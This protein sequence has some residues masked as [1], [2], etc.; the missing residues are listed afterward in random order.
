M[1]IYTHP[2]E[3]YALFV[4]ARLQEQENAARAAN[5]R[6]PAPWGITPLPSG[7]GAVYVTAD[8]PH[9]TCPRGAPSRVYGEEVCDH[10]NVAVYGDSASAAYVIAAGDP[11]AMLARVQAQRR[12]VH[13][14]Q[15]RLRAYRNSPTRVARGF[16]GVLPPLRGRVRERF[17][18]DLDALDYAVRRLADQFIPHP[19]H[20][21]LVARLTALASL[22]APTGEPVAR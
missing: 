11:A 8:A 4:L 5:D 10:L 7:S 12:I 14:Y 9:W 18:L 21:E 16:L 17:P 1:P 2:T 3:D 15:A 19:D 13:R 22:P 20:P 6:D